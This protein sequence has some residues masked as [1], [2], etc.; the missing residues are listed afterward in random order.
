MK[1]SAFAAGSAA[2][3]L[4]LTACGQSP[5]EE[6]LEGM[7]CEE[8]QSAEECGQDMADEA[9][10]SA[11]GSD[12]EDSDV[13]VGEGE[14]PPH[15]EG[16]AQD[17]IWGD[18]TFTGRMS[19]DVQAELGEPVELDM[20]VSQ[21]YGNYVG[22]ISLDGVEFVESCETTFEDA[23]PE[24]GH[25]L[26]AEVTLSSDE[27]AEDD[28]NIS[29]SDFRWDGFD[30]NP[31]TYAAFQCEET[32]GG[33]ND[34]LRPGDEVTRT[35][36]FDVPDT[37][38]VLSYRGGLFDVDWQIGDGA[39]S[40]GGAPDEGEAAV[41]DD[42]ADA[43]LEACIPLADEWEEAWQELD[44]ADQGTAAHD[45]ASARVDEVDAQLQEAGCWG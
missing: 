15:Y 41:S 26:I 38:G 18:R 2:L 5:E 9:M 29:E 37:D 19:E 12:A 23:V 1:T 35:K 40:T 31:A 33:T 14:M 32:F 11:P 25:F 24:F 16:V 42:D 28:W 44:A 7:G 39:E 13:W 10:E 17:P 45:E 22:T 20:G 3:L 4:G 21:S 30:E 43:L 34:Q 27:A 6:F 8:S 36:V